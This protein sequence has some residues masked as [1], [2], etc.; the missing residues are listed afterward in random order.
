MRKNKLND[1][2]NSRSAGGK[3]GPKN[4]LP[5]P[6]KRTAPDVPLG[7]EPQQPSRVKAEVRGK[8]RLFRSLL[9]ASRDVIYRL[10]LQTG[11]YEYISPAAQ[12]VVG[13]SAE[14]LMAMDA[15]T[16]LAMIHPQDLPVMR[17]AVARLEETGRA[18][19]QYRQ[20]AKNG[21]YRWLSNWMSLARD[22]AA[23]PLYRDGSIRDITE[24]KRAE[25]ALRRGESKFRAVVEH[26]YEGILFCDAD[27]VILYR[28]PSF[29]RITGF[30]A[31]ERQGR[32]AIELVHPDDLVVL[33]RA[34]KQVLA[35][36]GAL[37][38]FQYRIRHRDGN[39][40]FVESSIQNLLHDPDVQAIVI[41]SQD[42]TERRQAEEAR[43][44][45]NALLEG[46][47]GS[48][49]EPVMVMDANGHLVRTNQVFE[50]RHLNTVPGA[51]GEYHPVVNVF[52]EDGHPVPPEMWPLSRAIKGERISGLT[53]RLT[54]RNG[55]P[56]HFYRY[57]ANPVYDRNGRITH[58][59]V[60][61]FDV[62]ENRSTEEALRE[63]R[64]KLEA[65][66][67]SMTEAI[68]VA[69]AEGRLTDYNDEFVRYHRF[70]NREECSK[71]IAD[72]PRYLEA[73]FQDGTLAPPEMWAL[74]RALRGEA[75]SNV[76]Y[77]LCRKDRGETW[78][79]SYSFAPIKDKD[80]RIVGAVVAAREVT[81]RK[82]A[83][84]ALRESERR[85]RA[86]VA[87]LEALMEVAPVGIFVSPDTECRWMSGNRAAY[88]L[89]RRP[90][91]S[92]LSKS[93]PEGK[94]P[95]NFRAVKDGKEIPLAQLPMQKAA[96][97]GQAVR[98]HEMDFIFEDGVT[99][100]VLGNT[101]PLLDESGRPRGAVGVFLDITERKR[102]EED[103]TRLLAEVQK[104]AAELEATINSM[105]TGLIVYDSEGKAIR[106]NSAAERVLPAELF[107]STRTVR[108]L[109]FD[110]A[111]S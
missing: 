2:K 111:L 88:D 86:R 96:A 23:K 6:R 109:N 1:L 19:A 16:G 30:T 55:E 11:R 17:A 67:A 68:F 44:E 13:F 104:R 84:E 95:V 97:T 65:A 52:T 12:D 103:R 99:V 56:P 53:L 20:R 49:P 57:S 85:E 5:A 81:E 32:N 110:F 47:L 33:D 78:W 21:E 79:G 91:G 101:A 14:E 36:P 40:R 25:E 39:W 42:I 50:G 38:T 100:N 87:E 70:T 60:V 8:E 45:T 22:S 28:S 62:T 27:G 26:S 108:S 63:S 54:F 98:D 80:G 10:N 43:A 75:A 51:L 3:T 15:E 93:G 90:Q 76:E 7:P 92:N 71:T 18:E 77:R 31:E 89:L 35:A 102:A 107:S 106:M 82:R 48:I 29:D 73:Y 46:I 94:K 34:R 37:H 9:E 105:A 64:A 66:F 69:D 83:E 58:A 72:C 41:T 4:Q 59:V 74:P 61:F 24:Q